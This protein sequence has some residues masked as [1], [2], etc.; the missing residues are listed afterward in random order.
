METVRNALKRAISE[1]DRAGVDSPRLTAELLLGHVLEWDRVRVVAHPEA[2]LRPEAAGRFES[3]V[4]RRAAGEPFQYIVGKQE[5][6]G[7]PFRVTPAVLIPRPETEILVEQAVQAAREYS[8]GALRFVDVGTGS[9]CIAVSF[10]HE[11]PRARGWAVDISVEALAVARENAARHGVTDRVGVLIGDLLESFAPHPCFDLVL[12]NPPYLAFGEAASLPSVVRD[13]EPSVA[14]Y[15]GASNLDIFRRL[16]PQAAER[17]VP[18]GRLLM[19]VAA[20]L[21]ERVSSLVDQAGLSI[22]SVAGDLQGIP[23]CVIAR[24]VHG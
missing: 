8:S 22:E 4:Q 14:L 10:A 21:S 12:S 1:L 24:R 23:R 11:V 15:S 20:G 13:H 2:V 7:L 19:E 16:I 9:G 5:F 18:G 3:L 17:I 6:Y